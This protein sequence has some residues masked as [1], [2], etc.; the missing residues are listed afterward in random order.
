VLRWIIAGGNIHHHQ[1][2]QIRG[3]G[4]GM[5]HGQFPPK[6]MP[7]KDVVTGDVLGNPVAHLVGHPNEAGFLGMGRIPMFGKVEGIYMVVGRQSLANR[8]PVS[9][10]TKQAMEKDDDRAARLPIFLK[11]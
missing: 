11:I 6:A 2:Q 3:M 9:G 10:G 5:E 1:D 8:S 4:A 7:T